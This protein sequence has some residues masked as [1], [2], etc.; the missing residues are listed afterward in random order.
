[1]KNFYFENFGRGYPKFF[2]KKFFIMFRT[3]QNVNPPVLSSEH[4]SS[5]GVSCVCTKQRA[6]NS[7]GPA[8]NVCHDGRVCELTC[9]VDCW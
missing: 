1:M 8:K 7:I 6:S 3:S 4:I 2:P 9:D 5:V